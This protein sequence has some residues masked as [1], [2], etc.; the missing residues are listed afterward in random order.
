MPRRKGSKNKPKITTKPLNL[1]SEL[2]NIEL[3][4]DITKLRHAM[5]RVPMLSDDGYRI[6]E[7][8]GIL[9]VFGYTSKQI[10]EF[11]INGTIPLK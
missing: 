8:V 1:D 11:L 7:T 3:E 9:K 5:D 10:R 4:E 6:K 2:E